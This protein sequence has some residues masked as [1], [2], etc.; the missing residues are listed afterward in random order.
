MEGKLPP[1][2]GVEGRLGS[3]R[4]LAILALG[5]I[6][7]AGGRLTSGGCSPA[8]PAPQS[9]APSRPHPQALLRQVVD[10]YRKAAAYSDLGRVI[11][12]YRHRQQIREESADMAVVFQRPS[13]LRLTAYQATLVTDGSRL[14]ASIRDQATNDLDHQL[15]DVAAPTR[16]RR[17]SLLADPLLREIAEGGVAGGSPQLELLLEE[18]PL[19]E[20][21]APTTVLRLL[22]DD[23]IQER[24]CYRIRADA[25]QGRFILWV[26]RQTHVLRRIEHPRRTVRRQG[27]GH[28][29]V[30]LLVELADAVFALPSENTEKVFS[31]EDG[32]QRRR[33]R[34]L[35]M[36][37]P[38]LPTSLFGQ[39]P[40]DYTLFDLDGNVVPSSSF[41]G[42]V[43]VL[44]WYSHDPSCRET[45]RR[46]QNVRRLFANEQPVAFHAVCQEGPKV[47]NEQIRLQAAAWRC[48]LP[49]LRDVHSVGGEVFGIKALPA[50]IVLDGAGVLHVFQEGDNQ[51]LEQEF[52]V[53]LRDLL[54]G[55]NL[56][57]LIL[58]DARSQRE[59]YQRLL[60]ESSLPDASGDEPPQAAPTP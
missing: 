14:K 10:A 25:P 2:A 18:S 53:V 8:Q 49:L 32:S 50:V 4:P 9:R 15:L 59:D 56:A 46:L 28:E 45:L 43:T 54:L 26:D 29:S 7:A 47:S 58:R 48:E 37:P 33:V 23:D 30:E 51:Y 42:R 22:S 41:R 39:T 40:G 6:L 27:G 11:I 31:L 19:Q 24:P 52:P 55:K 3:P 60:L 35:V 34:R 36:P 20:F 5:V 17:E 12:R 13:R 1:S 44:V 16:L 38:P 21:L 57:A